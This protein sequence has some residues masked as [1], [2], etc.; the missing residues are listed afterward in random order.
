MRVVGCFVLPL[1]LGRDD[2]LPSVEFDGA[3]WLVDSGASG[4]LVR[5]AYPQMT[6]VVGEALRRCEAPV[7]PTAMGGYRGLLGFDFLKAVSDGGTVDFNFEANEFRVNERTD[8]REESSIRFRE[9]AFPD[10]FPN[11]KP[12]PMADCAVYALDCCEATALVDTASPVTLCNS[13]CRD[14][15]GLFFAEDHHPRTTTGLDGRAVP[16][17]AARASGIRVSRTFERA[18]VTFAVGDLPSM[19]AIGFQDRPFVLLG[20]DVLG[21]RFL[22]DFPRSTLRILKS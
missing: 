5:F 8:A 15:A 11:G 6:G 13:A 10:L 1:S 21:T 22:F 9:A 7:V 12:Y 19:A 16:L 17:A 14:A 4:S 20:L 18:D 3:R 2:G